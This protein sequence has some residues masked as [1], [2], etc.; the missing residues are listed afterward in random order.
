MA[1]VQNSSSIN[2]TR[3]IGTASSF[4]GNKIFNGYVYNLS[5]TVGFNGEPSS[6]I[7]NLALDKT[8]KN[9]NKRDDV[10]D[11]RK[12]AIATATQALTLTRSGGAQT[13][14]VLAD[15]DFDINENHI[16]IRSGYNI[17]I[18]SIADSDVAGKNYVLFNFKI[19]SYSISKKNNEKILTLTLHDNS[20][21]LNKIFVGV[22]GQ[23]VALDSRSEK[24]AKITDIKI[25]CPA[26]NLKKEEMR[27]THYRQLLH[28]TADHLGK[29]LK[30]NEETCL[31]ESGFTLKKRTMPDD[32]EKELNA[33][34][35]YT[36]EQI[37]VDCRPFIEKE[38]VCV[39][40]ELSGCV[41]KN[42]FNYITI[43]SKDIQ[44][45]IQ[46]GYG[47]VILVGEEDFK[48][49]QCSSSEVT[50]SFDTLL[51]AM[52]KLGIEIFK[53]K[54]SP[55]LIDKSKGKIKKNFSGTLRDVLNQWC[56]IYSYSYV[57]D[58]SSSS[59]IVIKGIDLSSNASRE[60][61]MLTKLNL[62]DLE[63]TPTSNFVIQSQDFDYDLSQKKLNLYSSFYFKEARDNNNS[64]ESSLGDKNF[65]NMNLASI[66]PKWFGHR[67]PIYL[68]GLVFKEENLFGEF[69][70][71]DFCGAERAYKEVIT[72]AVLGKFSPKLRQI[73][74]YRIGAFKALGFLTVTDTILNSKLNLGNDTELMLEE[75]VSAI[76]EIQSKNL[77]DA[78]GDAIYD[79]HFGFYNQELVNQTER[80]ESYIADFLG[81]HYWTDYF[82]V[83]EGSSGNENLLTQYEVT[84]MPAVQKYYDEQ[85][86]SIPL[87]T[88]G[89]F[90][91]DKLK[92]VY[93][94]SD[95]YFSAF[96]SLIAKKDLADK[97]CKSSESD[98][99]KKLADSEQ[100]KKLIFYSERPGAAYGVFEELIRQ[101]E[102][103]EYSVG[104]GE[105][106]ELN[107][108]DLYSPGFKELSPVTISLLQAVLPINIS[109]LVVGDFKFGLLY[110][111][112]NSRNIF[113]FEEVKDRISGEFINPIELQN[114]IRSLCEVI[115][116]L[117]ESAD[118]K[119]K[120]DK[121]ND[122]SKTVLYEIC[123]FQ[124]E[125]EKINSDAS[126]VKQSAQGPNPLKCRRVKIIREMPPQDI[127]LAQLMKVSL[128]G[129]FPVDVD[130][131][132]LIKQVRVHAYRLTRED[133]GKYKYTISDK[134]IAYMQLI[135]EAS[136]ESIKIVYY[137][138]LVK[139]KTIIF[140]SI[141]LPSEETYKIR[142]MTK[143][144]SEVFLPFQQIVKGGLEDSSDISKILESDALSV[145]ISL[146]NLT[147]NI[148]G[149]FG[150]QSA[151]GFALD[152]VLATGVDPVIMNY[153]GYTN[154]TPAYQFTTLTKFHDTL[155]KYYDEKTI[156]IQGPAVSFSA[157]LF[158]SSISSGL[159]DI[160]SVNNGL[161]SLNI[162]LGEGGLNLKCQFNSRPAKPLSMET[163]IY[164]NKPNIKFQNTNFLV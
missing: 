150:D 62:E 74:N 83:K 33:L 156:S 5:L 131:E 109:S 144:S 3:V 13:S 57:V 29:K 124:S 154:D 64:F 11:Q 70:S 25:F 160:L 49:S 129:R 18:G 142:L 71:L 36:D 59:E 7:L 149:L 24:I 2:I 50:Y 92:A 82:D 96:S 73:Y 138:D 16:G 114:Q 63:T 9:V 26:V 147:P 91:V 22:L 108:S 152:S 40:K 56:D 4:L 84:S 66:F 155:K 17:S 67:E 14:S 136:P 19:I 106:F 69:I 153:Q 122:C 116:K 111:I 77:F 158:C 31:L 115:G 104:T 163:L 133:I 103:F 42:Q 35:A 157:D 125:M 46:K 112:I 95:S 37:T 38:P 99:I 53:E 137:V 161:S 113:K 88:E 146:N 89:R 97:A 86:Y 85:L 78:E 34:G 32:C 6:L 120:K 101:I 126:A 48:D 20:I 68:D 118:L 107:L 39:D 151:P 12:K 117:N 58:F 61:V 93:E 79:F 54:D 15:N 60:T 1:K 80:I 51:A 23:H 65:F 75:A 55:S 143:T 148:R 30:I 27:T 47:A 145:D 98:Y 72:S 141:I 8:L 134:G 140:E 45:S 44:K 90:L 139:K 128:S 164:N 87:F 110:S 28:F 41:D 43:K 159:Q 94:G 102:I 130:E 100:L 76:L 81:Q 121:K 132:D 52:A 10:I 21:V 119:S 162:A 105:H 123:V 135:S 127:V